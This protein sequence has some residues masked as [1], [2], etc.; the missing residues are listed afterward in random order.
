MGERQL[1]PERLRRF[2]EERIKPPL[3]RWEHLDGMRS[4]G[5]FL[6]EAILVIKWPVV[7]AIVL[8]WLNVLAG[9]FDLGVHRLRHD[10]PL[11][12]AG[13]A[14]LAMFILL[15]V[16]ARQHPSSKG[17]IDV[18]VKSAAP[19][20]TTAV[21]DPEL[22]PSR[23]NETVDD[24]AIS[25]AQPSGYTPK[26]EKFSPTLVRLH[27]EYPFFIG[28]GLIGAGSVLS[29]EVECVVITPDQKTYVAKRP[30][31]SPGAGRAVVT[32]PKDF[33]VRGPL[34]PGEYAVKWREEDR[35]SVFGSLFGQ[36][37]YTTL[38]LT[39]FEIP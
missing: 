28:V 29:H 31:P 36:K 2:W 38:A 10:L 6:I 39:T 37:V 8:F 12:F 34:K 24:D 14:S 21:R 33:G 9:I 18:S 11:A 22:Q 26:V 20:A 25:K 16:Q 35:L 13:F 17:A 7:L 32:F 19:D 15:F 27:L 1:I 23:A 4:F 30:H 5:R 3:E